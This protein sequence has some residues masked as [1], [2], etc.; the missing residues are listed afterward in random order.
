[1]KDRQ[2]D[3]TTRAKKLYVKPEVKQVPLRPEEAV[4]GGC[5]TSTSGGP[6]AGD[7]TTCLIPGNCFVLGS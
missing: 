4:L 5:K 1:M 2:G 7:G 3:D 6:N